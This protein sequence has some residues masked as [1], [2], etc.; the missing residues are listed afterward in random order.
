MN[1]DDLHRDFAEHIEMETRE[2][3]ERGMTPEDARAAALRKFGNVG[4]ITEDTYEVWHRGWLD[5]LRQ[6]LR[7]ALRTLRRQPGFAAVAILTLALGI[8][9]NTAVFSV[10]NA[11]LLRPL[12]Y[13]DSDRIVWLSHYNKRFKMDAVAGA[14]FFDWQRQ[15]QSFEAMANYSYASMAL[16]VGGQ[17]DQIGLAS[18]SEGFF[19]ITGAR[20]A[21][22]RLFSTT[23]RNAVVLTHRLFLRRFGGDPKVIGRTVTVNGN[24]F[25][26]C[27]VLPEDYRFALPLDFPGLDIRSVEAYVASTMTPASQTRGGPLMIVAVAAKLKRGVGIVQARAELQT[28]D[29]NI[30]RA[31]GGNSADSELRVLP[32]R[33]KLVGGSRRALLVLLAAVGFVLLIACGNMANLLLA[34][35]GSRQREIA[36]RAAIGAGRG[37][38]IGQLLIEGSVLAL[39]G[40][41]AG[42]AVVRLAFAGIVKLGSQAVPRL[43]D[44]TIDARVLG[45]TLL[46]SLATGILFGFG[47]AIS[48]S[49]ANLGRMLKDGGR[50]ASAGIA[51]LQMRRV[52]MAAELALSVVLLVGAGLMIRSFLQMNAR[53]AGFEPE[54]L[55][56][57]KVSLSGAAYRGRP[58]QIAYFGRALDSLRQQPN[59]R[60]A[61][62][63]NALLGGFIEAEGVQFPPS[64]QPRTTF[65]TVSTGYFP[66]V[67]MRLIR[68]RWTTDNEPTPV[69]MVNESLARAVYG[70]TDPI[71]RGIHI[72]GGGPGANVTATIVGIVADLKY[73]K[74]DEEPAPET[75]VPYRYAPFLR[76]MNVVVLVDGNA[77]RLGSAMRQIVAD[78]DRTQPVYDV[79]TVEQALA[80]SI[81]PRRFNLLL[82]S[83]FAAAALALAVIGVYGVTSYAVAQ[84]SQEIGVRMALGAQRGAVVRMVVGQAVAVAVC[85]IAAG[86]VAAA[87]LTGIMK[88]LLYGVEPTDPATF[89][90]VC[91]ILLGA[92]SIAGMAPALRAARVDPVVA[93][94][95]E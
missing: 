4:R 22:G 77:S 48:L 67:G 15:A 54:R 93:L 2:N 55:L 10:V 18:V 82:L 12:P 26:V 60:A 68:G 3:L 70:A 95:Y 27:G 36:I 32:M 89:A 13:P 62:I 50:T 83:V 88:S 61:G 20:P 72:P 29:A 80:E 73:A 69:I 56:T 42:L 76:G 71:G 9:M 5:R 53:A 84:R 47:P 34:R 91:G 87:G 66:A 63:T 75:Y 79:E 21:Q 65:H 43:A 28:I 30:A 19:G 44:A 31:N 17:S 39:A 16:G 23:D 90:V 14:D 7:Y 41:A 64:Q 58:Q 59:V 81:A 24:P 25:I 78:V 74:L 92:A 49:R 6:D 40:G 1:L 57:M 38:M 45:F 8:G 51:G 85:G 11:V 52:L 33:D 94:R 37:R 86:V 46:L 35:A